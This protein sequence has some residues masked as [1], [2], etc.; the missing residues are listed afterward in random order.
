VAA[1]VESVGCGGQICASAALVKQLDLEGKDFETRSI[2]DFELKGVAE[3]TEVIEITPHEL[4]GKRTFAN[5]AGTAATGHAAGGAGD[6]MSVTSQSSYAADPEVMDAVYSTL[7]TLTRIMRP[8]E[9]EQVVKSLC[10]SWRVQWVPGRFEVN[11]SG[12][13]KRLAKA[14]RPTAHVCSTVEATG[15]LSMS[16]MQSGLRAD[17][18]AGAKYE[19]AL[20]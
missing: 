18:A 17:N 11:L 4:V 1:R 15:S 16:S 12:L 5:G 13:T 10:K 2:G 6:S 7:T 3:P 8:A 20:N 14:Y 19:T 9:R